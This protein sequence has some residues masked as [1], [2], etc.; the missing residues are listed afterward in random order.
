[1]ATQYQ[2]A[3]FY[4]DDWPLQSPYV[5]QSGGNGTK[6]TEAQEDFKLERLHYKDAPA[7]PFHAFTSQRPT[8]SFEKESFDPETFPWIPNSPKAE[9]QV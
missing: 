1:M 3:E 9:Y 6:N 5:E 8:R 2:S 4:S 7:I